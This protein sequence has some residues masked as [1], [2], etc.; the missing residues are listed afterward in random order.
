MNEE[1]WITATN[2]FLAFLSETLQH[3]QPL[4]FDCTDIVVAEWES[5]LKASEAERDYYCTFLQNLEAEAEELPHDRQLNKELPLLE[6]EEA[7]LLKV[8]RPVNH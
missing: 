4:C 7:Q 6:K 2:D 8:W 1:D 5:K 3:D